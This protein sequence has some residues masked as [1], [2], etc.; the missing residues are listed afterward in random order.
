M[1]DESAA[2]AETAVE[3]ATETVAELPIGTF[4][5]VEAADN[6][7]LEGEVFPIKQ[8]GLSVRL[9]GL[10]HDEVTAMFELAVGRPRHAYIL[11]TALVEPA[12]TGEQAAE[13]LAKK[14]YAGAQ[15]LINRIYE[16]S[17]LT[18]GFRSQ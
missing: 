9:R 7:P 17:G 1:T 18:D 11:S 12:M 16:V 14:S 15:V 8:W 13:I 4:E 6:A 10:T 5:E 3:E 2:P